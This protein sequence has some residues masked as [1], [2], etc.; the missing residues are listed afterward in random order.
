MR[1][2]RVAFIDYFPTH[3]RKRLYE[4][5]GERL[6]ADFY[7]FADERE[8]FW[9]PRIPLVQSGDFH[10]VELRR[11][12]IAGHSVM[13]GIAPRLRPGR[14]DAVIKS[15]NGR[16]M[17]PLVYGASRASR[18]PFV[19]WTGMWH[20]PKT[21]FHH[22]S[23]RPA[24]AVYRGADSIVVYGDHVRRFLLEVPGVAADKVYVAGQAVRAEHF[25]GIATPE[26]SPPHALFV[27]QFERRKGLDYLFDAFKAVSDPAARLRIVGNGSLESEVH[28]RASR[29]PR[30]EVMGYVPQE[31]L[32]DELA[33]AR[34]LVLSS[35]TTARAREPWGLVVNEA[36]H[37][38]LPVIATTAVGAAAGGL[39]VDGRNGIVVPERD[40]RSLAG[41]LGRLLGDPDTAAEMGR[42]GADDAKAFDYDRMAD[43]FVSAVEHAVAAK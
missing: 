13:P 42:R 4:K 38:G 30:I 20:H 21:R 19:L 5:L 25:E 23:R 6:D 39:V 27:G 34:C 8:H 3:Y 26:T 28:E 33:R 24:E 1:K 36:M 2:H 18:L 7:F 14:Y 41:A 17:L 10:R 16:L 40:A 31:R 15:L 9:N 37:A 29:D 22:I 43:A 32:P 12:R 11:M 35:V